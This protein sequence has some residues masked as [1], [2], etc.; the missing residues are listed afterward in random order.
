MEASFSDWTDKAM[1]K[2]KPRQELA[3]AVCAVK[4]WRENRY[5]VKLF[6]EAIGT[7]TWAKFFY[8]T[9]LQEDVVD[10]LV[11]AEGDRSGGARPARG[12]LLIADDGIF[13]VGPRQKVHA[14]LDVRRYVSEWHL[15]P[16]TELHAPA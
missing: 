2:H 16:V 15:I 6:G 14:L 1:K 12:S 9:E 10:D 11:D 4:D 7:T 3:C 13:C 8:G 5:R